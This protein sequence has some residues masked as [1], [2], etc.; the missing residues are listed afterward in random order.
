MSILAPEGFKNP[1]IFHLLQKVKKIII[2]LW[3]NLKDNPLRKKCWHISQTC[4][5]FVELTCQPGSILK[6]TK[7]GPYSNR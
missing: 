3:K 6:T 2:E 4:S 7:L 1:L 5:A